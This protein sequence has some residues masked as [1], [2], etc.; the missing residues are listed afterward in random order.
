ME[1]SARAV[2]RDAFGAVVGAAGGTAGGTAIGR[3]V[4]AA[5]GAQPGEGKTAGDAGS[6]KHNRL[7]NE[8]G[9]VP[10][11]LAPGDAGYDSGSNDEDDDVMPR[12]RRREPED[13]FADNG[14]HDE[15]LGNEDDPASEM[16]QR[17]ALCPR[18]RRTHE[19]GDTRSTASR[20]ATRHN[21]DEGYAGFEPPRLNS[22]KPVTGATNNKGKTSPGEQMTAS[23]ETARPACHGKLLAPSPGP[24]Q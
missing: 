19:R 1:K 23:R 11:L 22:S 14:E 15:G 5:V 7:I 24:V 13:D 16:E 10:E 20:E 17:P 18:E 3:A 12:L 8:A 2:T 6:A 21:P 9:T 4:G